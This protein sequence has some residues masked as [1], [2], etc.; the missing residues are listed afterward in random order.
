MVKAQWQTLPFNESVGFPQSSDIVV[1]RFLFRFIW[2][3]SYTKTLDGSS[4]SEPSID[5]M[6]ICVTD[7]AIVF[8]GRLR[9]GNI[10][11]AKSQ[12]FSRSWF[13]IKP[14]SLKLGEIDVRVMSSLTIA[15]GIAFG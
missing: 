7:R 2:K 9:V 8:N 12:Q 4:D 6:V 5:L 14:F 15:D 10:Y 3:A 11:V 13:L 1:G